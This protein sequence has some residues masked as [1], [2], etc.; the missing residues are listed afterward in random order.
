MKKRRIPATHL[1]PSFNDCLLL[2]LLLCCF[3]LYF[4]EGL[5]PL[6][7]SEL[8]FFWVLESFLLPDPSL[9]SFFA[10]FF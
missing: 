1:L 3:L 8:L 9:L 5:L 4:E 7:L 2:W 10:G 6:L